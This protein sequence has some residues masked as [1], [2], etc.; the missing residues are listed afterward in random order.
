[1]RMYFTRNRTNT[2]APHRCNQTS[3]HQKR[4]C[5]VIVRVRARMWL[6]YA[7][8]GWWLVGFCSCVVKR[9]ARFASAA[10]EEPRSSGSGTITAYNE[11]C[12]AMSSCVRIIYANESAL[13]VHGEHDEICRTIREENRSWLKSRRK[14]KHIPARIANEQQHQKM[15]AQQELL[16]YQRGMN[17][18]L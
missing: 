11:R 16:P 3:K 17:S 6:V 13:P 7:R 2:N 18:N 9:R 4:E 8:T 15:R 10:S 14:K 12:N 1:M 5:T